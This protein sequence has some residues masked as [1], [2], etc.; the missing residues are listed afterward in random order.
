MGDVGETRDLEG[1]HGFVP[2]AGGG[3]RL[4]E[5]FSSRRG[6][7]LPCKAHQAGDWGLKE[8][9]RHS[10]TES[11]RSLGSESFLGA[12]E[13][14][15][16]KTWLGTENPASWTTSLPK[17]PS[18]SPLPYLIEKGVL[19]LVKELDCEGLKVAIPLQSLVHVESVIQRSLGDVIS[20]FPA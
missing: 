13:G 6:D 20:Y 9:I 5:R 11:C 1:H 17:V 2:C 3:E 10:I 19:R 4:P 12:E 7:R 15:L 8:T 16:P 18:A 14:D